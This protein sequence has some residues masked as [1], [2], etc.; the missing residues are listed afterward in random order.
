M[1]ANAAFCLLSLLSGQIKVHQA[2]GQ[3]KLTR[4]WSTPAQSEALV[5]QDGVGGF[6]VGVSVA[7]ATGRRNRDR[8][9]PD[10]F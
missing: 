9:A 8:S 6:A 5:F 4:R 1:A 2:T 10:T 7:K 3:I